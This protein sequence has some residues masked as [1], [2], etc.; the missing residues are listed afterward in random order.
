LQD[1]QEQSQQQQQLSQSVQQQPQPSETQAQQGQIVQELQDLRQQLH[2]QQEQQQRM[3]LWSAN[4]QHHAQGI[5]SLP[6]SHLRRTS[7]SS[8]HEVSPLAQRTHQQPLQEPAQQS[9]PVPRLA[10][11][12]RHLRPTS[13]TALDAALRA[14]ESARQG[15]DKSLEE[16][17]H[18]AG[19]G[20]SEESSYTSSS[21]APA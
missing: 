20:H 6:T 17:K 12:K 21:A 10:G 7:I 15:E 13:Q 9:L 3:H 19:W 16:R 14:R 1:Q 8:S 11:P 2:A 4:E 18:P 5:S